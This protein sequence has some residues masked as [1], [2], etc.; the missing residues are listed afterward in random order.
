MTNEQK[1]QKWW[2]TVPG[3][4]TAIAATITAVTGLIVALQQAG[5]FQSQ[6]NPSAP[7]RVS[8]PPAGA[9][10]VPGASTAPAG[11]QST[12]YPRA[13]AAGTEVRLGSAA[14]RILAA[15]LDRRNVEELTLRF[16][17][18]MTNSAKYPTNFWDETFRLVVDGVPRAPVGGLNKL[19]QGD[20][21][22]EG[23]VEFAVPA[24]TQS[25][26]LQIRH[27]DESTR[28]PLDLAVKR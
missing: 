26:V 10:T 9:G 19:V 8:K 12:E 1:P 28:I 15:Q 11:G 17:V 25:A 13:L 20:S 5:V 7:V 27:S 14:Y 16:T 23:D 21:A 18:R 24:A 2:Q 6:T 22:A 4:L 3:I